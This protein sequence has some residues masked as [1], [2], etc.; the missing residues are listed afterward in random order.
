M[1]ANISSVDNLF[2]T[3]NKLKN[4]NIDNIEITALNSSV[5]PYMDFFINSCIGLGCDVQISKHLLKYFDMLEHFSD[6]VQI[7]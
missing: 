4:N 1:K 2:S 7:Q 5:I 3:I 6:R